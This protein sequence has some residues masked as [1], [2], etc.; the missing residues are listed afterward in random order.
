ME[1]VFMDFSPKSIESCKYCGGKD[2]RYGYLPGNSRLIGAPGFLEDQ[3]L[4]HCL[5]CGSCGSV[6]YSWI[7]NPK[8]Y[9]KT[10]PESTY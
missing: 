3:E 10:I 7:T 9:P 6:V 8:K 5:V 1:V 2:L 4:I